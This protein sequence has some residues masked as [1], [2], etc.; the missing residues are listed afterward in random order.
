[1]KDCY[2]FLC[3][4]RH[5]LARSRTSGSHP[6]DQGFESP[7]RYKELKKTSKRGFFDSYFQGDSK[8]ILKK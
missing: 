7:W 3:T 1:M 2:T 8:G 5:R 6:E 4:C